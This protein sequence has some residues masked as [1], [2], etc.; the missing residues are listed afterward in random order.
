MEVRAYVS[1][2][3]RGLRKWAGKEAE[4]DAVYANRRRIKRE[5]GKKLQRKR[6]ELLERSFA[7]GYETGGMRRTHLKGH[8]NILKRLLIH[9]AGFN[10]SLVLRKLLGA[11]TPRGLNDLPA[12]LVRALLDVLSAVT[13]LLWPAGTNQTRL[14]SLP[15]YERPLLRAA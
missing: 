5:R 10:L 14:D 1:E 9:I 6:S 13:R 11:G 12:A 4:R 3:K 15:D 7:H 8:E 2:P